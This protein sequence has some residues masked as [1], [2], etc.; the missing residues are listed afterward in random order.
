MLRRRLRRV[1][2]CGG[3][4]NTLAIR[5][6]VEITDANRLVAIAAATT[7]PNGMKPSRQLDSIVRQLRQ[8][9]TPVALEGWKSLIA[10]N[11]KPQGRPL[12]V[13]ALVQWTMREAYLTTSADLR[14]TA[15][16]VKYFN[17]LK[18]QLREEI[19][20]AET[21]LRAEQPWPSDRSIVVFR[22][23][24]TGAAD[25]VER[26]EKRRVDRRALSNILGEYNRLLQAVG[27]DAQ[28]A[29]ID[30]QSVLQKQQQTLQMMSNISKQL[31]DTA[32]AIIRKLG[33]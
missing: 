21:D 22:K 14:N 17:D 23:S 25:P 27:N 10:E 30:M 29:N 1:C 20:R 28:L 31:K 11:R 13:N 9:N 26:E 12:D 3:A 32:M 7:L 18:K 19:R 33:G 2:V 15:E 16:K 5:Q 4:Q 8:G 24:F 6:R